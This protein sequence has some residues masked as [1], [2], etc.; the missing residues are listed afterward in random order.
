MIVLHS[1]L[2]RLIPI[3]ADHMIARLLPLPQGL[4]LLGCG[5]SPIMESA[6]RRATKPFTDPL[7]H[8]LIENVLPWTDIM[9]SHNASLKPE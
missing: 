7:R 2:R 1:S 8:P 4:I 9:L 3:H 5:R 6:H